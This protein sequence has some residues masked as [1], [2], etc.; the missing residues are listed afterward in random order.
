MKP[1]LA[2]V[3]IA[4]LA[5]LGLATPASATNPDTESGEHTK[6]CEVSW[7]ASSILDTDLRHDDPD[8]P[9]LMQGIDGKPAH[10]SNGGYIEAV[11][12]A[13]GDPGYLELNHFYLADYRT[14]VWRIPTATDHPIKD[15]TVTFELA[16]G[17]EQLDDFVVSFDPVSTNANM[18]K[19][20][21]NYVDY[22]WSARGAEAATPNADGS[23]TIALGDLPTMGGTVYQFNV[24]NEDGSAF[25]HTDRFIAQATLAGDYYQGTG[26]EI[27][28]I[29][30]P[31]PTPNIDVCQVEY[32]G[33]TIWKKTGDDITERIKVHDGEISDVQGEVNADGWGVGSDQWGEGATRTF[34]L[35]GGTHTELT[36]V[37]YE[38][39]AVQGFSFDPSTVSALSTPGG[40]ALQ[41]NGLTEAIEGAG[42]IE[43]VDENT[44]R[45]PIDAMPA[46]SSFSF[47]VTG[48]L[49][50]TTDVMVLH[51]RLIGDDPNCEP[52]V[53]AP[54]EEPTPAPT[55]EPTPAP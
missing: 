39:Q 18:S 3:A 37:E 26:C 43:F 48:V 6:L 35:Y 27:P 44:I 34:R 17:Y 16:D 23:W 25:T 8:Y 42:A 21:G 38:V 14:Q 1:A 22:T 12:P 54:T 33:T 11:E 32:L 51:H 46:H 30:N 4:G 20:G 36:N 24:R 15:A 5:V 29:D 52:V 49:D 50:E 55:E 9:G 19:W 7:S 53:P 41:G 28:P 45:M 10:Y 40:G 31:D 13:L 2:T 47:N